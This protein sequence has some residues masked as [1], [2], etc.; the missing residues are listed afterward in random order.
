MQIINENNIS[1]YWVTVW[2]VQ[3]ETIIK[4]WFEIKSFRKISTAR[5]LSLRMVIAIKMFLNG[6]NWKLRQIT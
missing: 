5:S 4:C 2:M 6:W 3:N 1:A